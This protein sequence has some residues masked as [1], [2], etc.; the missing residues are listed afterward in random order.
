MAQARRKE[1]AAVFE[2][3]CADRTEAA[4][5][6]GAA[7]GSDDQASGS[8]GG[9]RMGRRGA[10]GATLPTGRASEARTAAGHEDAQGLLGFGRGG[11][12]PVGFGR[13]ASAD[14]GHRA[15]GREAEPAQAAAPAAEGT[16]KKQSRKKKIKK[17]AKS[18]SE[19]A[20]AAT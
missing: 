19:R 16:K 7:S 6:D 14:A 20:S 9:R 12:L 13:P 10:P 18:S 4:A 17:K 8:G 15:G 2:E 11:K 5:A 1:M 3:A